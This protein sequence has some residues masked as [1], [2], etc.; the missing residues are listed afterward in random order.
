M[1]DLGD[2]NSFVVFRLKEEM[3][4]MSFIVFLGFEIVGELLKVFSGVMGIC[5]RGV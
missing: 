3:R 2:K 1:K 4:R 5:Y